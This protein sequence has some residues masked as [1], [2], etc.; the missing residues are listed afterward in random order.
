MERHGARRGL[1]N[2]VNYLWRSD[3]QFRVG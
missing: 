1:I 2:L 3:T